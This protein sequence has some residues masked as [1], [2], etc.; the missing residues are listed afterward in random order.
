M[1]GVTL[2]L[3]GV[4]TGLLVGGAF[5]ARHALEADHIAAVATLVENERRPVRTGAAWGVGHSV[6]ILILG[7]L[8]LALDLRIPSSIATGF[9]VFVAVILV[10]LGA[11]VLVGR[12]ALG[13]TV[14][15]HIHGDASEHASGGHVH[16]NV[17][18]KEIGLTHS[19]ADEESL[20]VGIIH[21]LAGS[22]GV[23]VAL[24]A[25]APT[26]TRGASFLFGFAIASVFAMGLA[27]WVWGQAVGHAGKLRIAAGVASILVGF[28]L[29]AEIIGLAI[30]L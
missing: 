26:F 12:E 9:E 8:F 25:A 10:A 19:H 20:A 29:F 28:L 27:A 4:G 23:V 6:P 11:R 15:R 22:G 24:A 18:G 7:A 2:L 30:P 1:N 5:G 16:V 14:L 21:G 3:G 17:R 13:L